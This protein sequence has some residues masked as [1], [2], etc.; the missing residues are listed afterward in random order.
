[1]AISSAAG[2]TWKRDRLNHEN[3]SSFKLA[4]EAESGI[5]ALRSFDLGSDLAAVVTTM[6][7]A[8]VEAHAPFVNRVLHEGGLS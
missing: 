5:V 8:E 7:C 4:P 6:F 2:T 3:K 1:M